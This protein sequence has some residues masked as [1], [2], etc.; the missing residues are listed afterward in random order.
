VKHAISRQIA[1]DTYFKMQI[2][3]IELLGIKDEAAIGGRSRLTLELRPEL[4]NMYDAFHGG[5]IMTMLDVAMVRAAVSSR[6]FSFNVLTVSMSTSF[7]KPGIG[8]LVV[9]GRVVSSDNSLCSCEAE[10][11][12]GAGEVVAKA[13]GTFKFRK[14][15]HA[16]EGN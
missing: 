10:I 5:V 9:E 16:G 2:P 7:L 8:R 15:M 1:C 12:D 13:I 3:F 11:V 6:D 14:A 4:R